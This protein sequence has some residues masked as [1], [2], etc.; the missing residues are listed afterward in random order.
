MAVTLHGYY[1]SSTSIRVRVALNYK[2]VAYEQVTHHLRRGEHRDP[3]YLAINPQ[4]LVP[5][6]L[7]EA[8]GRISQSP[9]ILEWL[10]EAHPQPPLLPVDPGGRARVRSLAAMIGCEIHPLN[11]LRVLNDLKTRFGADDAAVAGWFRHW[12]S[13][14][15]DPLETRLAAESETGRFCHGDTPT[16]AD[17]YLYAQIINNGRFGI[18]HSTWPTLM[19]IFRMCDENPAF[20]A[21]R[22]ENQPDA[23]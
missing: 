14:T 1:R 5:V 3:D 23:E 17:I 6:L 4:G 11:N 19:R 7:D 10:E 12:V 18:D 20:H 21:A 22:P 13:E 2:G 16:L 15:F 8:G 9:A